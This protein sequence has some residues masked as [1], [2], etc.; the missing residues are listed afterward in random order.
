MRWFVV[1]DEAGW[2]KDEK[3]RA[4]GGTEGQRRGCDRGY[5]GGRGNADRL[6]RTSARVFNWSVARVNGFGDAVLPP[7]KSGDPS[8]GNRRA[9]IGESLARFC[10]V[11]STSIALLPKAASLMRRGTDD[12]HVRCGGDGSG[13][14]DGT[15]WRL[16]CEAL[17]YELRLALG[18]GRGLNGRVGADGSAKD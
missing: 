13:A 6:G 3:I 4:S 8:K 11:C 17:G 12:A 15:G 14:A 10:L 9:G 7:M 1:G 18:G 2:E 5:N 16:E